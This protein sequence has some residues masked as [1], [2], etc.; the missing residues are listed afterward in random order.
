MGKKNIYLGEAT[1]L[2]FLG[3][4]LPMPPSIVPLATTNHAGV[5][6]ALAFTMGLLK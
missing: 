6:A 3:V 4:L 2:I 5:G 1:G